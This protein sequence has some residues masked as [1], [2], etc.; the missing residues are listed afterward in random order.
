MDQAHGRHAELTRGRRR[1]PRV[2]ALGVPLLLA[3]CGGDPDRAPPSDAGANGEAGA[4]STSVQ[5]PP[6]DP[7]LPYATSIVSFDPGDGAGY[8]QNK[9][10]NVVLGPPSGKGTGSGSTDVLSLGK[11]G[12]IVLTFERFAIVDGDGPD[13]VV[14][15]NP[16]WPGGDPAAVYAEPGEVSVSEDGATWSTFP[17]DAAGDGQGHYAGCAGVTPTLAY[18]PETTIPLDP[19]VTGGDVFDLADLGLARARFVKI[20]DVSFDGSAP[21]AGF[22]LDAVGIVNT[23][24]VDSAE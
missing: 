6:P 4:A 3:A 21:T 22:D 7:N 19:S 15:E 18:D 8:G 2:A 10:P 11:G 17:C 24:P 9:L 1:F 14:F 5:D 16:F 12:S 13:L 23:A 20:R